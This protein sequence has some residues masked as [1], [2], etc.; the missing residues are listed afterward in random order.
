MDFVYTLHTGHWPFCVS[1]MS[2]FMPGFRAHVRVHVYV[3]VLFWC[4]CLRPCPWSCPRP[5]PYPYP[6][7]CPYPCLCLLWL[8]YV[9]LLTS[10]PP[11]LNVDTISLVTWCPTSFTWIVTW[12]PTFSLENLDRNVTSSLEV[13][14][15]VRHQPGGSDQRQVTLPPTW[16]AASKRWA[17]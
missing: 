7:M 17:L 9:M 2:M 5:W 1:L 11:F 12:H 13:P 6:C 14:G 4:P 3:H 16:Q 8:P 10:R 15:C